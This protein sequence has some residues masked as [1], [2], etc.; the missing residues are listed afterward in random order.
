MVLHL[1]LRLC[2]KCMIFRNLPFPKSHVLFL[3]LREWRDRREVLKTRVSNDYLFIWH[4]HRE[5]LRT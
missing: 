1:V 3:Y 2:S 5:T 4:T